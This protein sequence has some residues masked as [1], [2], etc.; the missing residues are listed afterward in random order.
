M[1]KNS[2]SVNL[3][4]FIYP[5]HLFLVDL[6]PLLIAELEGVAHGPLLGSLHGGLHELVIDALLDH[7][8]RGGAAGLTHVEEEAIVRRLH[9]LL[10][11]GV[12]Q[13]DGRVLAAKLQGDALDGVGSRPLDDFPHL[14]GPGERYLVHIGMAGDGRSRRVTVAWNHGE[15]EG[16][17]NWRWHKI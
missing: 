3:E 2:K 10:D 13:H 17:R 4:K 5:V 11:V 9:R 8:A 14:S 15:L 16:G 6:R 12:R 1:H 7:E